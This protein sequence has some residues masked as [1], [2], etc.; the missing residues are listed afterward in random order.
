MPVLI[1]PQSGGDSAAAHAG[2]VGAPAAAMDRAEPETDPVE[3][4][5]KKRAGRKKR[6]TGIREEETGVAKILK[7]NAHRINEEFIPSASATL[8]CDMHE[9]GA[10]KKAR[11]KLFF[12]MVAALGI[13]EVRESGKFEQDITYRLKLVAAGLQTVDQ[14][15]WHI[16]LDNNESILC[17]AP[18]L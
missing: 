4:D 8:G 9:G 7:A 5:A 15:S 18:M 3:E 6:R 12:R 11:D 13:G 14:V 17:L 1:L 16:A 10:A 2:G